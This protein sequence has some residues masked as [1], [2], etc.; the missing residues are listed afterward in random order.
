MIVE[1]QRNGWWSSG[2]RRVEMRSDTLCVVG[3]AGSD[4]QN[5]SDEA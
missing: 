2:N 5:R 1:G 4:I 3:V